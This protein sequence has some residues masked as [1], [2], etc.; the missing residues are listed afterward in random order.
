MHTHTTGS[1]SWGPI[2]MLGGDRDRP[3]PVKHVDALAE[4]QQ[5]WG[6]GE[7][8][9]QY[10]CKAVSSLSCLTTLSCTSLF[11]Y[12]ARI[13]LCQ[14]MNANCLLLRVGKKRKGRGFGSSMLS[15]PL[16]KFM[17]TDRAPRNE[18]QISLQDSMSASGMP[19]ASCPEAFKASFCEL[20]DARSCHKM[21]WQEGVMHC[22]KHQSAAV[23]LNTE[24]VTR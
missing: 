11:S 21:K 18:V 10:G 5:L 19:C 2:N 16:A 14:G 20:L 7:L 3:Q 9:P 22:K 8:R 6:R 1:T 17:G 13:Q 12:P 23:I 15:E 24:L 4:S